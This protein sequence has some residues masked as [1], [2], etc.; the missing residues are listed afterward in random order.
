MESFFN[1]LFFKSVCYNISW[2][3]KLSE[4]MSL[5]RTRRFK[6]SNETNKIILAIEPC[7]RTHFTLFMYNNKFKDM[8]YFLYLTLA[9]QLSYIRSHISKTCF[10]ISVSFVPS[11]LTYSRTW[12][13][14]RT[15][16]TFNSVF[17]AF[18]SG[19]WLVVLHLITHISYR[20]RNLWRF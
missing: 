6:K 15:C 18:I 1:W 3:K 16:Q 10:S 17:L 13:Y 14:H 8:I 20:R 7:W 9:S 11:G 19:R 5:C 12:K 2:E 4:K